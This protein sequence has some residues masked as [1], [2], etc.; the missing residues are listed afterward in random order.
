MFRIT[1][2]NLDGEA[3]PNITHGSNGIPAFPT[4]TLFGF[5]FGEP[6]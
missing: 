2:I 3:G 5:D 4:S 6:A 1:M